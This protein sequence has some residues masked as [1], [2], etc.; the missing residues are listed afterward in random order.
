MWQENYVPE[1]PKH[2]WA[3]AHPPFNTRLSVSA[4]DI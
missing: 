4:R 1:K 2:T 3:A